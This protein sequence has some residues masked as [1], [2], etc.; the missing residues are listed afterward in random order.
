MNAQARQS[1]AEVARAE[2][3]RLATDPNIV[4]VGYGL[5]RR[6][7]QAVYESCIQYHVRAKIA[8]PAAIQA[9][10]SAPV[11]A[12]IGGY[13][14]D[15]VEVVTAR[16]RK[17]E[18]PPT[19][20]RGSHKE[21]P[22][23]GGVSTTVLSDWHSFPTGFGTLGGLCFDRST[24]EAMAISNAHVWGLDSGKDCIQ[25]WIPTGE[26]LEAVL[27]LLTCGPAAF[28][29]DT[30]VP[31]ALTVGLSAAAAAAWI[32]A[33]A[34]DA[35]DPSRWGQRT[36][37]LPGVGTVTLAETVRLEAPVPD[38]PFAGRAYYTEAHWS[39]TRHA[40]DG[41]HQSDVTA[42]RANEHILAGKLVWTERDKYLPGHQVDICAEVI[43]ERVADPRQY[44]VVAVCY[45]NSNP[46]RLVYRVLRPG[47]CKEVRRAEP[48]CLRGFPSFLP[49]GG[50]SGYTINLDP[51]RFES[52]QPAKPI[53]A[54]PGAGLGALT[55]LALPETSFRVV[56][57][58]STRVEFEVL[59]PKNNVTIAGYNS[60]GQRVAS[61]TGGDP[62]EQPQMLVLEA[63]EMVEAVICG[64]RGT[65]FLI[66]LCAT[67]E[68]Y[69]PGNDR[70][71]RL[72]Y[73]GNLDLDLM[74][75]K[76]RWNIFLQV[77]SLDP[78]APGGDPVAA[79]RVLGGIPSANN[80]MVVGCITIMLLDHVFD[81]I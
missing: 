31:S 39:Y 77:H 62:S 72:Y 57:P 52:G 60:A 55:I 48:V 33:A 24:S 79:A 71:R 16:P 70:L 61:T 7:G 20:S 4:T 76:D 51:F 35:E 65:A 66:G 15:V 47:R 32:A 45:P 13:P 64:G 29:L 46:D 40:S 58:P 2:R 37:S 28:I 69:R 75:K 6:G 12:Q 44:H 43:S 25:P 67:K 36:G 41:D 9:I 22:L 63:P 38:F 59:Q 19:G 54:P 8:D 73:T 74:E 11:P 18:G 68:P 3:Q 78:S 5:R 17:N 80:A 81:V 49:S 50:G 1:L 26:Y 21:N 30:T 42:R 23:I 34:S 53:T 10:G 56:F 14:T 27:K